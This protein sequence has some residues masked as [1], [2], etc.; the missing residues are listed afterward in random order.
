MKKRNENG[1]FEFMNKTLTMLLY[2]HRTE[3]AY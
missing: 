1:T 2:V 3:A